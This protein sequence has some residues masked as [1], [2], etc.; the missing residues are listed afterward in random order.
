MLENESCN[1]LPSWQV[2]NGFYGLRSENIRVNAR[3]TI[4]QEPELELLT[5]YGG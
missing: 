3:Y 2:K 1:V 5:I 4:F